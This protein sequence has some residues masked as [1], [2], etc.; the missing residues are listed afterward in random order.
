MYYSLRKIPTQKEI[1]EILVGKTLLITDAN[2]VFY[3]FNTDSL[4]FSSPFFIC[5]R[6]V[7]PFAFISETLIL[8]FK[9]MMELIEKG[10]V[11]I[12][13][14]KVEILEDNESS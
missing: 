10:S 14:C 4:R 8:K 13:G 7:E 12:N 1:R 3:K 2:G 9:K 6:V 11:M 5:G